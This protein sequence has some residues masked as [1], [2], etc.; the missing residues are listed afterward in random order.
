MDPTVPAPIQTWDLPLIRATG[1]FSAAL[2]L[3]SAPLA[4]LAPLRGGF[5]SPA[6]VARY[7]GFPADRR[8]FSFL[9]GRMAA[10]AAIGRIHSSARATEIEIGEG[11]FGQPIVRGGGI[12]GCQVTISHTD[13]MGGAIAFPEEHPMG[14]DLESVRPE[15]DLTIESQ[16]SSREMALLRGLPF[17]P[18]TN[19]ALGWSMKE[20]LSKV[21]KC[22]LM[23]PFSIFEVQAIDAKGPVLISTFVN[24]AQ[25]QVLS[26]SFGRAVLSI[27][28]PKK[29]NLALDFLL[30]RNALGTLRA[31]D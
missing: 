19:R 31:A 29:T 11:V 18:S 30:D 9:S 26:V 27:A 3:V 6:E 24:F 21:L 7:A 1:R 20:S 5:L 10:K 22:G 14:L 28:L 13:G 25:Y 17:D 15:S 23:S 8:R 16:M 4:T 2:G 12:A